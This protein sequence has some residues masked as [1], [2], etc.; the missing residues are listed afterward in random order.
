MNPQ[1]VDRQ[2]LLRLTDLPNIGPAMAADL[3]RLGFERPDELRG[4]DAYAL[5]DRLC[6]IDGVRHDPCVLDVFLS[7]VHFLDGDPARPWWAYS[8]ARKATLALRHCQ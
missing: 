1:R 5:Y 3:Q 8:A 6:Q 2:R 7:V 4:H